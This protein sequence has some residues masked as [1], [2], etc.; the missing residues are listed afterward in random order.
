MDVGG[1]ELIKRAVPIVFRSPTSSR[2]L[3]PYYGDG[4]ALVPGIGCPRLGMGTV[5][6]SLPDMDPVL[7]ARQKMQ[8]TKYATLHG[9]QN[10]FHVISQLADTPHQGPKPYLR[11]PSSTYFERRHHS[12]PVGAF[13]TRL[14]ENCDA[15]NKQHG[16]KS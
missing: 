11:A 12:S 4:A 15:G 13:D 6:L 2:S 9:T 7:N 8:S 16:A 1:R 5:R 3:S 10:R 14:G